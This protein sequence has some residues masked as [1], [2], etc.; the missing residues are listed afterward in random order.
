MALVDVLIP[1]YRRKTGL[2]ITLT[3][4]LGQT[5]PERHI[6]PILTDGL[7][8]DA[9]ELVLAEKLAAYC[10]L[11]RERLEAE[12]TSRRAQAELVWIGL[13]QRLLASSEA[14]AREVGRWGSQGKGVVAF[15]IGGADGLPPAVSRGAAARVSLSALTFPHRLA[16]LVLVEQIYRAM[17]ILRGEPYGH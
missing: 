6:E 14:F 15:L 17:T 4:L 9:P 1:T 12:T 8:E 3:S 2:A 13:Q 10:E 11:R 5:F 16:R 7:P